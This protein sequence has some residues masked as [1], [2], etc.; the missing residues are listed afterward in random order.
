VP[1]RVSYPFRMLL[2]AAD[3]AVPRLPGRHDHEPDRRC[4]AA[5]G[6]RPARRRRWAPGCPTPPTTSTWPAAC[7]GAPATW[8]G[9][10]SSACSSS[11]GCAPR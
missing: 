2:R 6:T 1:G 5:T 8:S 9:W 4:W 11:S 10:C 3:A 7:C